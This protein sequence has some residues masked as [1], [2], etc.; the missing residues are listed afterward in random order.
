MISVII[1]CYNDYFNLNKTLRSIFDNT[2]VE[3]EV[4][5]IDDKSPLIEIDPEYINKII[6]IQNEEN[7]GPSKSR[8]KSALLCS[9]DYIFTVDSHTIFPKGWDTELLKELVEFPNRIIAFPILLQNSWDASAVGRISFGANLYMK[10]CKDEVNVFETYSKS[11]YERESQSLKFASYGAHKKFFL[12]LRGSNDLKSWGTSEFC[13]CI[14]T[15]L[16]GGEVVI[17]NKVLF[18]HVNTVIVFQRNFDHVYYNKIRMAKTVLD[19]VDY[20][21]FQHALPNSTYVKNAWSL[22]EE[23]SSNI[24]EYKEYYKTIFSH[25]FFWFKKKFNTTLMDPRCI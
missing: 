18:R 7:I 20:M 1:P 6:L 2:S 12:K 8:Y 23:D 14:K 5:V 3:V 21:I 16:S 11:V 13:L 22:I 9:Y 24:E 17:N 4:I 10:S 25:D 15:W 19:E